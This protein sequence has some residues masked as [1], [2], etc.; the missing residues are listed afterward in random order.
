MCWVFDLDEDS[1]QK[2]DFSGAMLR[3]IL[4]GIHSKV[5]VCLPPSILSFEPRF[6]I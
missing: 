5:K 4:H 2:L 1:K 6:R 3:C